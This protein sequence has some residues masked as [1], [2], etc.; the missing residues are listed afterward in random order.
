MG[1]NSGYPNYMSFLKA[2]GKLFS[3]PTR[4]V[5]TTVRSIKEKKMIYLDLPERNSSA[6]TGSLFCSKYDGVNI[7]IRHQAIFDEIASGNVPDFLR[8]FSEIQITD[9][10][11]KINYFVLPDY[12]AIGSNDDFVRMPMP[13]NIAQQIATASNCSLI[14]KKISDDIWKFS[15]NKISQF[16][17]G[18][19]NMTSL[20]TYKKHNNSVN[21]FLNGKDTALLSAGHHKDYVLH[22]SLIPNNPNKRTAIYGWAGTSGIPIQ[23]PGVQSSAHSIEYVDYSQA[24]RLIS[25]ACV[26]NDNMITIQEA[27]SDSN[28]SKLINY[29]GVL[30]FL[31][32]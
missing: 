10:T 1:S 26:V 2:I 17:M 5:D 4:I 15:A 19:S 13:V 30:K 22:N 25:N 8:S 14:T 29:D 16:P 7:N 11:N 32:F 28:I 18:T 21:Q 3:S 6:I 9:G 31:S 20:L 23:G 24:V 27:F 12:L